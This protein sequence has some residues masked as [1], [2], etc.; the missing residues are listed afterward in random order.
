M[1]AAGVPAEVKGEVRFPTPSEDMN[2]IFT[3]WMI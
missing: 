1:V 3:Q 2:Q